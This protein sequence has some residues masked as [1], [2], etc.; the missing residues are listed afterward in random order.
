MREPRE[1]PLLAGEALAPIHGDPRI[2]KHLDGHPLAE[3]IP[4]RQVDQSHPA[5]MIQRSND[6]VRTELVAGT[7]GGIVLSEQLVRDVGDRVFVE[8]RS[9]PFVR[10]EHARD[11]RLEVVIR[12][13]GGIERS[14]LLGGRSADHGVENELDVL[15]P[16]AVHTSLSV[17]RRRS[18]PAAQ[19]RLQPG[20]R[21]F[22]VPLDRGLR[23]VEER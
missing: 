4:V 7:R 12:T 2:P 1:R 10:V 16:C 17:R 23:Y 5:F 8:E 14:E 15:P 13:T 11:N 3:I 21:G 20:P 19:P 9:A 22:Q 18:G 6:A